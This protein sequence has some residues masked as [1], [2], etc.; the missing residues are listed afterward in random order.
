MNLILPSHN[1]HSLLQNLVNQQ[2]YLVSSIAISLYRRFQFCHTP[3]QWNFIDYPAL[4]IQNQT[5][6]SIIQNHYLLH[7]LMRDIY[8]ALKSYVSINLLELL[9]MADILSSLYEALRDR[10]HLRRY[11]RCRFC[12]YIFKQVPANLKIFV[13][14]N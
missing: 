10:I 1:H 11:H 2:H 14:L 7:C 5:T 9:R 3:P 6:Y 13:P 12:F 8:S 4:E